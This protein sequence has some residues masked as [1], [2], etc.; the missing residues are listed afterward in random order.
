MRISA[1]PVEFAPVTPG[2][3]SGQMPYFR[4]HELLLFR[5]RKVHRR[6]F[7]S[8]SSRLQA[9]RTKEVPASCALG[10][11][12][13]PPLDALRHNLDDEAVALRQVAFAVLDIFVLQQQQS[14]LMFWAVFQDA[15]WATD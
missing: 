12:P 10:A 5:Q 3:L 11:L 15:R 7:Y 9:L 13:T 14:P 6:P 8:W 1:G 4:T 2:K